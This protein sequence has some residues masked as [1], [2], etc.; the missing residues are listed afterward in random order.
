[1]A[2]GCTFALVVVV[3][4]VALGTFT[5]KFLDSGANTGKVRLDVPE[6]YEPGSIEFVGA[7]N[8]F[9]VRLRD[10]SFLALSDLDAANRANQARRCRVGVA[11]VADPGL[12]LD[13][14]SLSAKMSPAAAGTTAILRENCNG[15]VYDISGVLLSSTGPN[16][17]RYPIEIA[18][19]GNLLV[20]TSRRQCSERTAASFV[21]ARSCP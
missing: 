5:V 16:L 1:V 18:A 9:I 13:Q 14:P 11:S 15:A 2:L 17:D 7:H 21:E 20:D 3:A 6:A 4:L 12:P 8:F 19:S 10:G